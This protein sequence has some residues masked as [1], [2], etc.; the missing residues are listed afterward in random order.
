MGVMQPVTGCRKVRLD[1][2]R[3]HSMSFHDYIRYSNKSQFP[4]DCFPILTD[5]LL[6]IASW[7]QDSSDRPLG[8]VALYPER[9]A[10]KLPKSMQFFTF[11]RKRTVYSALKQVED[12]FA[13]FYLR[14]DVLPF[15]NTAPSVYFRSPQKLPSRLVN[16][17]R[18]A[19]ALLYAIE[20]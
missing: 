1:K 16:R 13:E 3:K 2:E 20:E 10:A 12:A 15:V 7:I 5:H 17:F 11:S 8:V 19:G 6:T 9:P 18:K 4:S 14:T